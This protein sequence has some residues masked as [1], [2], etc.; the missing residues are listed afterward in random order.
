MSFAFLFPGQGSQYV[1]M[2]KDLWDLYPE[3]R[4][5]YKV[6]SEKSGIDIA[7]LSFEGPVEE[8]TKT[9]NQQPAIVTLSI[10]LLRLIEKK[11]I[12]PEV[13]AGHSL[14]EYSALVCAGSLDFGDA[15]FLVRKRGLFMKEAGESSNGGM[16]AVMGVNSE[17]VYD[18]CRRASQKGIVVPANLN[19]PDQTVIS[20]IPPALD[21]FLELSK[22]VKGI[23]TIPLKVSVPLHS[24]L[25]EPAA[26]KFKEVLDK[27]NFKPT[28]IPVISNV[29]ANA[30]KNPDEIKSALF[31]QI[32][33]PVQWVKSMLSLMNFGV[34][35][36]LEIGPGKVL[37]GL[38][39]RIDKNFD[40]KPVSNIND[41]NSLEVNKC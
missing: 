25:M 3:V 14:G 19:A 38:L 11:G 23:K 9:E 29:S 33:S 37:S 21:Y 8:L 5:W 7:G 36:A 20:G 4:D 28:N 24:P 1:G 26:I 35:R 18:L 12:K 2:G 41:L 10:C 6:A 22:D 32:Y 16:I 34:N 31:K 15:I 40:V 39:K 13:T 30:V 27:I 17:I